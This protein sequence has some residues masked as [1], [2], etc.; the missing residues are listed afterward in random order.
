MKKLI[1]IF[2]FGKIQS[3]AEVSRENSASDVVIDGKDFDDNWNFILELQSKNDEVDGAFRLYAK[4]GKRTIQARNYVGI[5]E[6]KKKTTIEILPKIFKVSDLRTSKKIFLRMLS[7]LNDTPY[8]SFQTASIEAIEKF[9]IM[10]IFINKFIDEVERLMIRGIKKNYQSVDGNS[11]FIKGQL[12]FN[13]D[14]LLN[15]VDHSKFY[16]RRKIYSENIPQNRLIRSAISKL[17]NITISNDNRLRLKRLSILLEN[18]PFSYNIESDFR[19]VENMNRTFSDYEQI[20]SWSKVFLSNH[21]FT[22]FSGSILNQALLFPM[23]KLFESYVAYLFKKYSSKHTIFK[24]H[25]KYYLV[26]KHIDSPRFMLRPDI[27]AQSEGDET[28][29][30]IIIDTKWKLI[31]ES[32]MSKKQNYNID[33]KDMYQLYAY[34]KKYSKG[35]VKEPLLYLIY[36]QNESF[37]NSLQ[38]FYYEETNG[39]FHL[40]LRAIPF[41]LSA[42]ESYEEQVLNI[43]NYIDNNT[44][45]V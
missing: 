3:L 36:P 43:L 27:V 19:L 28:A 31:D 35:S 39:N 38:P 24:Q 6:T 42:P 44:N 32:K 18:I 9:P 30:T 21:G 33:I 16:V 12:L 1:Q 29:D 26:D 37:R 7:T 22:N 45:E 4:N 40:K 23:D 14:I 2:E 13:Q 5:L 20:L 41:D 10:E 25:I 15:L 17:S 11:L 34:G 8:K